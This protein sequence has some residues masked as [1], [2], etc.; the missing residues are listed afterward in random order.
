MSSLLR[1]RDLRHKRLS[2]L[3]AIAVRGARSAIRTAV[4][5]SLEDED[6][7]RCWQ[8]A[9]NT[10]GWLGRDAA[11]LL[12]GVARRGPGEG[13][14]VEVGAY[15]GKATI[16]L[17][18]GLGARGRDERVVSIDPHEATLHRNDQSSSSAD[19]LPLFLHNLEQAGLLSSVTP[20]R[21]TSSEAAQGWS[22]PVRLLYVDALHDT[23]SV[24][25]D[26]EMWTPHICRDG[27]IVFDDYP[28]LDVRRALEMAVESGLLSR[29]FF[30]VG[31]AAVFGLRDV[32][33]VRRYVFPKAS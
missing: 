28:I 17:G 15:L 29:P 12:F 30:V 11:R 3:P 20:I 4:E 22:E 32:G 16:V 23:L 10:P 18:A 7:T 24:L 5:E 6:F 14:V 13:F 1:L 2:T 25:E 27:V 21:A 9:A 26:I 19:T 31:A 33:T 8:L